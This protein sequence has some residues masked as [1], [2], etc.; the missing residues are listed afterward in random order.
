MAFD[1][2]Y[3]LVIG[4]GSYTYIPNVN[5][6]ISVTDAK[7]V[8]DLLCNKNLCGYPPEQVTL[9]Y[10]KTSSRESILYTLEV[11]AKKTT[12]E[13]TVLLYYCGHGEY[14]TDGNYYLTTSDTKAFKGKVV[15]GTGICE[16]ELLDKLRIIPAKRLL[17]LFNSC[18][19][20]EISPELGIFSIENSFG[21]ANLPKII[22]EAILSSGEGRIIITACRPE[23]KSWIG[24]GKLSIFTQA[25]VDGMGG[26]GYI[27]NNNGYISAFSLYEH[28]YLFVKDAV[29]KLGKAQD[30]ELTVI[31]GIGP[32]PVSLYRGA[33]DLGEF[34]SQEQ[35]PKGT[36]A[37]EINPERS[38][39]FL[40]RIAKSSS[41]IASGNRAVSVQGNIKG[42]TIVTGDKNIIK[43]DE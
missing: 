11:L 25:L 10:D 43:R 41:L 22:N 9:L 6:P 19:S 24:T 33:T 40:K 38:E 7:A 2:G 16:S 23:Q 28:I 14:G 12:E 1:K 34:D 29:A 18:H 30:P 13:S 8:S 36:A 35:V 3:A 15:K 5:I 20:G 17:L 26:K 27:A 42:S 31:K 21:G 32:F 37:F 39:R 4:V